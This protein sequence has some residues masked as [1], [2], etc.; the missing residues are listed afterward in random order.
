MNI[1]YI[2]ELTSK[3]LTELK[4]NT[5]NREEL[6]LIKFYSS[7]LNKQKTKEQILFICLSLQ[8]DF[9]LFDDATL[10]NI[11]YNIIN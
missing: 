9:N 10:K 7:N 5:K 11:R 6:K 2:K 8:Y 4:A 3:K 1:T